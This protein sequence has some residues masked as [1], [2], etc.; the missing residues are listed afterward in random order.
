MEENT[1]LTKLLVRKRRNWWGDWPGGGAQP[2][3]PS[4]GSAGQAADGGNRDDP[5]LPSAAG[6]GVD[7]PRRMKVVQRLGRCDK[8]ACG[9]CKAAVIVAIGTKAGGYRCVACIGGR[10]DR[11]FDPPSISAA[12]PPAMADR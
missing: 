7:T 6:G 4:A 1:C 11:S 10:C 3:F 9:H 5:L 2:A 8:S 12:T